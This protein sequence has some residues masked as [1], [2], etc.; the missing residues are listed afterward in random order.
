MMERVG[1]KI[2]TLRERRGMTLRELAVALGY[3]V[4]RNSYISEIET[5]KRTP[6]GKF[7]LKVADFFG[8]TL[9]QLMRDELEV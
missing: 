3:P 1:E 9:D 8:I 4:R 2:R 5:G 7:L 6:Q